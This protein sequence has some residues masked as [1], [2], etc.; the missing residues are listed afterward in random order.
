MKEKQQQKLDEVL[1]DEIGISK[2]AF[3]KMKEKLLKLEGYPEKGIETW[4]RLAS[5]NLYTRRQIVDTKS[6]ILV[7]INS[8]IISVILGSLYMQLESDPHLL[9]GIVPMVLTN[10]ISITFAVIATRPLVEKGVFLKEDVGR[11]NARL[12]TF[13]DFYRMPEADYE[14]AISEMMQDKEFLYNTIKR[15]IHH[16]G[17]D[18]SRR[19]RYIRM[20]YDVFLL[21]LIF[22]IGMFGICHWVY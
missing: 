17:I 12:M 16:L 15:D 21:G 6:N 22:S 14:W 1:R 11:G 5:R 8:I 9:W 13:D 10:L 4:F 7:T 3:R 19:Y 20:A 2:K 18:L